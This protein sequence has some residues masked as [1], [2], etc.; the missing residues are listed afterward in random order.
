[1][2]HGFTLVEIMVAVAVSALL[3]LG[4]SAATQSSA[5]IADRQKV[6]A[7]VHEERARAVELL[8]QDWRGRTKILKPTSSTAEE[9]KALV[10]ETTADSLLNV[11]ST[12]E[13]AW[14]VSAKGL[15]RR[16]GPVETTILRGSLSL[17]FW[18]GVVWGADPARNSTAIRL[19]LRDPEEVV[20]LR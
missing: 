1:M 3:V 6:E 9:S 13:V 8:R 16:E 7:R 4:V 12:R 20:I 11:R 10:L 15:E 14:K 17:E 5:L 2:S 19:V 18:D